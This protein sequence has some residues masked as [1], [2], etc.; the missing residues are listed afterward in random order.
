[1]TAGLARTSPAEI[2][3]AMAIL[4]M[5]QRTGASVGIALVAILYGDNT[6]STLTIKGFASAFTHAA[7]WLCAGALLLSLLSAF[8]FRAER[9]GS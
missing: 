2:P 6:S 9:G 4:N 1:M 8:Y 5:L 7:W 3:D